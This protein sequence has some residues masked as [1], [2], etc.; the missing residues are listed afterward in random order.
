[1]R[2]TTVILLATIS[3]VLLL[4]VIFIIHLRF[5]APTDRTEKSFLSED[6]LSGKVDSINFSSYKVIRFVDESNKQMSD[7]SS[8]L[9]VQPFKNEQQKG[10]FCFPKEL[11]FMINKQ[12]SG[13]TLVIKLK[14]PEKQLA[15]LLDKYK[16]KRMHSYFY[17]YTDSTSSLSVRNESN[18]LE[19]IFKKITLREATVYVANKILI[20]SC[21]IGRLNVS[22][23]HA[24]IYLANNKINIFSL[25]LE[26]LNDWKVDKCDISEEHLTGK[27][28]NYVSLPK[29]E[30]KKMV[31]KGKTKDSEIRVSLK[32]DKAT[33]SF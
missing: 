8:S 27:G 7:I 13:D 18:N 12:V 9:I 30:C 4:S 23:Y 2:R 6:K 10:M 19:T 11:S 14:Y 17:L 28:D 20:D 33:I 5:F 31:W 25:D 26:N 29:T 16:S 15:A 32:S 3:S 24:Q 21:K 1:M 22:G